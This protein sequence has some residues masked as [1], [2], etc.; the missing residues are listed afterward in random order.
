MR[1]IYKFGLNPPHFLKISFT[2][3]SKLRFKSSGR[4]PAVLQRL[5]P[6][7]ETFLQFC[8]ASSRFG[9]P[10]RNFAAALPDS[11]NLPAVLRQLFP[12]R[13]TFLQFCSD[14]SRLGKPSCNFA[15]SLPRPRKPSRN[16]ATSLPNPRKPSRNFAASFP[17][18]IIRL[19]YG[20]PPNSVGY[21]INFPYICQQTN[22]I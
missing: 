17:E 5:F 9:K 11:G 19:F 2:F 14:P 20:N 8:S 21:S 22:F 3:P 15:A 18:F 10:S 1:Q 6:I 12:I 4:L 13:E 7:R 16:F